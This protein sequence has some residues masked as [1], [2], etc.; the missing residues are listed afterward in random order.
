MSRIYVAG[1]YSQG[2][3]N[4]N[5]AQA[6]AV[7][8]RV[9]DAGHVPF[10]PHLSHFWDVTCPRDYETW[11]RWCL[12]WLRQCEALVRIAGPSSGADREV[13]CAREMKIPVF[14][15]GSEGFGL[16]MREQKP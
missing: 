1:P 3:V 9:M 15:A 7:G 10:V 14:D 5:V 16:W 13:V 2:N 8:M 11:M 12:E 4:R 6:M